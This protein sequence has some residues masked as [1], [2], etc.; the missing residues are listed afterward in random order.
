M[1]VPGWKPE[2]DRPWPERLNSLRRSLGM[3]VM[4]FALELGVP[5]AALRSW[6]L[7]EGVPG[8]PVA[9]LGLGEGPQLGIEAR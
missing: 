9:K 4:M 6:L 5:V 2:P 3:D 8:G 1:F 7:G